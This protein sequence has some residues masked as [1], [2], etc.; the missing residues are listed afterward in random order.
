MNNSVVSRIIPGRTPWP[1]S[2]LGR[3]RIVHRK[4]DTLLLTDGLS[5]PWDPEIHRDPSQAAL[6]FEFCFSISSTKV[7]GSVASGPWPKLLYAL[8]DAVVE[9]QLDICGLLAKFKAITFH[10]P[11]GHG[12]GHGF[13]ENGLVG[14]FLG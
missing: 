5:D 10:A 1:N 7:D 6:N 14:T 9:D 13:E 12:F 4:G 2:M 8:T 11:I 3:M